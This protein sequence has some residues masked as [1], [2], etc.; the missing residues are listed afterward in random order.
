MRQICTEFTIKQKANMV[1]AEHKLF[2]AKV[3]GVE[4]CVQQHFE[5]VA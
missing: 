4:Q 1:A 2:S 3:S 5:H